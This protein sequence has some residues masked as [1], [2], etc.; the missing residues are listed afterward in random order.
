MQY[1]VFLRGINVGGH[2][3]VSM[4]VLRQLLMQN[5]YENVATLLNSGNILVT[6]QESD[7]AKVENHV[8]LLIEKQ[9]GFHVPVFILP[10]ETFRSLVEQDPFHGIEVHKDLRLYVSYFTNIKNP[11][12]ELPWESEDGALQMLSRNDNSLNTILDVSVKGTTDAM[13]ILDY[14]FGKEITTRNW[15]TIKK[16]YDMIDS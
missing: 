6:T 14:H 11:L 15:N 12:P 10:S 16:L 3:K 4:P 1:V 5:A 8:A 7:T 9:F 13:K 2:K